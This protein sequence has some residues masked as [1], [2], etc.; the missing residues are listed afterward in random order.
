MTIAG[1]GRKRGRPPAFDRGEVLERAMEVFW[2]SGFDGSS[3]PVL[4]AAM[5]ISAQS[6]YAAFGSKDALYREAIDRYQATIGAFADRALDEG[7]DAVEAVAALL[8]ESALLF[9]RTADTP[10]CMVTTAPSGVPGD[11]LTLLGR[12]LRAEGVRKL[13]DRLQR[14][15][16]DGQLRR[17][18]D[19]VAWA[20]YL[21][22]VL[23]GMSVQARDGTSREALLSIAG[24]AAGCLG[25]L[26]T[27]GRRTAR[28]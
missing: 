8:R 3:I 1:N 12:Q 27:P 5:G 21:S 18:T 7:T 11:P 9:S 19:C 15:V 23:Q 6:L 13:A 14:G 25:S 24:I 28:P 4:T 20:R 2:A 22:S 26:R 17:D 16:R 10:G